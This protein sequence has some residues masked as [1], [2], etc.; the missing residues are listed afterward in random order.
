MKTCRHHLDPDACELCQEHIKAVAARVA[1]PAGSP[2]RLGLSVERKEEIARLAAQRRWHDLIWQ[3]VRIKPQVAKNKE[4]FRAVRK[5]AAQNR[6]QNADSK[7][8]RVRAALRND[9]E[10]RT[11]DLA[12]EFDLPMNMVSRIRR[13]MQ[14][15]RLRRRKK[16]PVAVTREFLLAEPERLTLARRIY[17]LAHRGYKSQRIAQLMDM[18]ADVVKAYVEAIRSPDMVWTRSSR[19]RPMSEEDLQ[20]A[21]TLWREGY[22]CQSIAQK[23]DRPYTQVQPALLKR[24]RQLG[25]K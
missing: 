25:E 9:P 8:N 5:Q 18:P 20:T 14:L 19:A 22:T 16:E 23:L 15:P 1:A 4:K 10:R 12:R 11:S 3:D 2:S 21:V 17:A 24:L 6:W 13:E 7:S